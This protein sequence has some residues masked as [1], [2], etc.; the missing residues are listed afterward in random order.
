MS[1][2]TNFFDFIQYADDTTLINTCTD[3]QNLNSVAIIN[4]E[5]DKVCKW[6]NNNKLSLNATKTKFM[7]FHNLNKKIAI[8][9]SIKVNDINIERVRT[10]IF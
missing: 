2:S 6:L 8:I 5:I 1:C 10:L 9:P 7:I 3:F 4:E